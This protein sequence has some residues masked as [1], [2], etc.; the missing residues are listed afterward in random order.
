[1]R[2]ENSPLS[3][4]SDRMQRSKL[5]S[6]WK[7]SPRISHRTGAAVCGGMGGELAIE[8]GEE[9]KPVGD[10][11]LGAGGGERGILRRR[12]SIDDEARAGKR[13]EHGG[14][15]RIGDPVVRPSKPI[16]ARKDCP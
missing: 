13:L 11:K 4:I 7:E 10:P 15:R 6:Y 9:R 12:C 3:A 5:I 16:R 14:E 1:M 8:F 2:R